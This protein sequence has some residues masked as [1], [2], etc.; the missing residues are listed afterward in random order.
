MPVGIIL[1][2]GRHQNFK[3]LGVQIP[4]ELFEIRGLLWNL[5]HIYYQTTHTV[6]VNY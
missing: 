1:S 3:T 6:V 4:D 2:S 5:G